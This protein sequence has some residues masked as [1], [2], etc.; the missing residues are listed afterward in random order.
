MNKDPLFQ[1][2]D[3]EKNYIYDFRLTENSPAI[4]KGND[5]YSMFLPFDMNGIPRLAGEHADLGAY[6]H[7]ASKIF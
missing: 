2:T 5:S 7:D 6:E 4:K 3:D 1:L